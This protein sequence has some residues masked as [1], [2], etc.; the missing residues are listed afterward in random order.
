M[1]P[2]HSPRAQ[3]QHQHVLLKQEN[4][5]AQQGVASVTFPSKNKEAAMCLLVTHQGHKPAH[6]QAFR[7]FS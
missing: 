3:W 4:Q 6:I 5:H 1:W 2:L 7:H